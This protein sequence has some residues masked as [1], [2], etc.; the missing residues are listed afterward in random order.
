MACLHDVV[1]LH[2]NFEVDQDSPMLAWYMTPAIDYDGPYTGAVEFY[3]GEQVELRV[4]GSGHPDRFKSFQILDCC[5]LTVPQVVYRKPGAV[6]RYAQPSPFVQ[7]V[8]ASFVFSND[9]ALAD[10]INNGIRT[11]S[12]RWKHTLDVSS[13]VGRWDMSL[14]LTVKIVRS[15]EDST[16]IRV[17]RF[18]PETQVG[19]GTRPRI[20]GLT[21][22]EENLV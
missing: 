3:A 13:S 22:E 19:N 18:D 20:A 14:V 10:G 12:Q 8:G 2:V 5:L 16:E 15:V 1:T 17:F 21:L 7:S 4:A 11:V 9:F 6:T